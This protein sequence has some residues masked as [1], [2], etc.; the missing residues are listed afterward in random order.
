MICGKTS[1]IPAQRSRGEPRHGSGPRAV[2]TRAKAVRRSARRNPQF[3]QQ[4]CEL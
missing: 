1:E 3:W 2:R 4:G